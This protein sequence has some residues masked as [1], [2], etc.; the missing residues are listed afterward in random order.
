LGEYVQTG[1]PLL[2]VHVQSAAQFNA[3]QE[4]LL[5]AFTLADQAPESIPAV[6]EII[7]A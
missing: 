4:Q 6:Y 7:R 2:Y 5:N 3:V 1:E